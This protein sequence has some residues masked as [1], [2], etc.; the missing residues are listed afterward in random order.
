MVFLFT[1]SYRA[2]V[3]I[4]KQLAGRPETVLALE[5]GG[6]NP[7]IVHNS[8]D[9]SRAILPIIESAYI[10]SGQRCTCAR[11][12][13]LTPESRPDELLAM[14]KQAV[15]NIRI[16]LPLEE[17]QPFIGP[18]IRRHAAEN[19]LAAQASL[20][21]AGAEP[22]VEGVVSADCPALVS[23]ILLDV[24]DMPLADEEHFG[25]MLLVQRCASLSEAVEEAGHT[26]FGLSL[27]LISD[28]RE[29]FEYVVCNARAGIV[30]WN[31]QTTGA[32]GRLPFGGVG[33]SGNH[34]PSGFYAADYCS[35]PVASLEC[36]RAE[37]DKRS[38]GLENI[39]LWRR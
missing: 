4:H 34:A 13:L 5:M 29:D 15:R 2:G 19:M 7:L 37:L 31:R 20:I 32:S 39:P 28:V 30:N 21:A 35:Y 23:P 24:T 38:P 1:G 33:C 6:N 36:E 18:L 22:L 12:L 25:P 27:G 26:R 10:T 3:S 17:P 16:G 11:R 14:L 8:S 9:I